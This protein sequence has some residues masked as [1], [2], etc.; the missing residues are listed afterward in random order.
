MS[1]TSVI[2]FMISY[3][4]DAT[5]TRWSLFST[6]AYFSSP[7]SLPPFFL[8]F[9]FTTL[10]GNYPL[11]CPGS[12]IVFLFPRPTSSRSSFFYSCSVTTVNK[13]DYTRLHSSR[14]STP[15]ALSLLCVSVEFLT[16]FS[17][18]TRSSWFMGKCQP[19]LQFLVGQ[20]S[21]HTKR[22]CHKSLRPWPCQS[23][24][25][26]ERDVLPVSCCSPLI[27]TPINVPSH[28]CPGVQ[29]I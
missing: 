17:H 7:F 6:I 13:K 22:D 15:C 26:P 14:P 24:W 29:D 23:K 27:L 20:S 19:L 8:R 2:P 16:S 5:V 9:V 11:P 28:T 3:D 21:P 1:Y 4:C 10:T 12:K 25:S 18:S